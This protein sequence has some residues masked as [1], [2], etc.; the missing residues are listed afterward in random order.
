M[1]RF[2][3]SLDAT[4]ASGFD[5]LIRA[6]GYA[7]RSEA[8]RDLIRKEIESD[9][10]SQDEAPY[11]VATLSYVYNHHERRL[12][13]RLTTSQHQSHDMVVSST[14]VHL[15]H[16]QCLET[17]FLKGA[18]TSV[19]SLAEQICAERGVR[20]GVLNL[21]PVDVRESDHPHVHMSPKT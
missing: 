20:H 9:R 16:D 11:C 4:L 6:R 13:E 10:L 17:L 1:E 18:T 14:H 3:I 8:V 2:T 7:S 5:Y 21:I 15:D 12:A 19:R